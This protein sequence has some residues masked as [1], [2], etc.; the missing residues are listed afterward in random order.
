MY[1]DDGCMHEVVTS[2][3]HFRQT[4]QKVGITLDLLEA[5]QLTINLEKTYALLRLVGPDVNKIQKQYVKKTPN[6][7]FLKI[8]RQS[9]QTTY[10]R[11]VKQFQYLGAT[12]CYHNFERATTVAR[13]KASVKTGQQL[14]RWLY[15]TKGFNGSQ[16]Y[17]LWKQCVF[18]TMRYS[19]MSVGFTTQ[20]AILI[21]VACFKQLRRLFR[22]PTHL[23]LMTHHEFLF[24]YNLTDPLLHLVAFCQ[25]AQVRHARR[26]QFLKP[27]DVL[28]RHPPVDFDHYMQ[29]LTTTWYHQRHRH[30]TPEVILPDAQMICPECCA[31]LASLSQL[32]R[33][34]TEAHGDRSGALRIVTHSDR[35]GGVPTCSRCH[36]QFTTHHSLQYHVQFVCMA[37]RQDIEEVEHRLRVQEMLQYARGQQLQALATDAPLL[38]YFHHRCALCSFF[39]ATIKGL[40]MHWQREHPA[41]FQRHEPVNELLLPL[42]EHDSPCQLCG[43]SFKQY[44]KCHIIRQMAL[45]LTHEGHAAAQTSSLVC[46]HCG[47]AYTTRHGLQQHERRYHRAEEAVENVAAADID[48]QCLIHQAVLA[49]KCEDLLLQEDIQHFLSSRC[50]MC[51]KQYLGK[52]AVLRHMKQNHASLWHACEFHAVELDRQWKSTFGCVCHP[53]SYTKHI[54]QM[55]YQFA[56]LRLDQERQMM[57]QLLAEPPDVVLSVVEQIEPLL[58]LGFVHNLY[59]RSALKMHLTMYCQVCGYA[60]TDAEDLRLHLHAVHPVHLQECLYLT[61]LFQWCMFMEMGC[62]CNPSPGW[63]FHTMSAWG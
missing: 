13:I 22:E 40:H 63:G 54:C 2:P 27:T 5:A 1:A 60:G 52:S 46:K 61:E 28:R 58:W 45:L 26:T 24:Q 39:S 23:T 8:P 41:E 32:R 16:K 43:I 30:L 31:P 35:A 50:L 59:S 15:T 18:T 25:D 36:M 11:L 57:P 14:H 20:T 49:N 4:I 48:M 37:P 44:H 42:F 6:G 47:K 12:V 56:M 55:Y 21:D 34:L 53:P 7:T 33:H 3:E 38:A 10:I 51:N 9:G 17:R 19:L 62:F 29:V